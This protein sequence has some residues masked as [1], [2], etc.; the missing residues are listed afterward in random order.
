M[1]TGNLASVVVSVDGSEDSM[2]ARRELMKMSDCL[3][4]FNCRKIVGMPII[5]DVDAGT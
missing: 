1:A 4:K 2:N 3:S 5:T